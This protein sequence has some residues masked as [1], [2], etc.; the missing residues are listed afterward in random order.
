MNNQS[1]NTLPGE[2]YT[3]DQ[4]NLI[5]TGQVCEYPKP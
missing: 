3:K 5:F 2:V 4:I 1:K